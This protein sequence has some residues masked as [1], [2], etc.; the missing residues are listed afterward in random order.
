MNME[1]FSKDIAIIGL[2]CSFPKSEDPSIFFTN[3]LNSVD[4]ISDFTEEDLILAGEDPNLIGEDNY[5]KSKGILKHADCFDADFFGLSPQEASLLDPQ[6]RLF[7]QSCWKSLEHAGYRPDTIRACVG[8]F[9]ST[10]LSS[11]LTENLLPNLDLRKRVGDFQLLLA[12]DKDFLATRVSFKLN[13]TGPSMTIQ[14]GCS[15]SLVATHMACQSI[16]NGDCDIA[17]AGGVSLSFPQIQ[18]YLYQ[19]DMI[20]SPDGRCRPFDAKSKGTVRGSGVGVVV[21]KLL[22]DALQDEDPIIAIIKGSAINNDGYQKVGFTAPSV[23][24]QTA[25]INEALE[26]A[27]IPPQTIRYV[28]GH[29]TGTPL[30][31][32]IELEALSTAFNCDDSKKQY[33]ALGSV[34]SNIGHLD[35]ASGIAGLIK[36]ALSLQNKTIPPT[37]HWEKS[38]RRIQL[39][40][41]PFYVNTQPITWEKNTFPRRAAIS[42]FG[43]GGTNAHVILEEAPYLKSTLQEI[44]SPQL[45]LFSANSKKSLNYLINNLGI[46]LQNNP[47]ISL[48]D[49]AYTLAVA[50]KPLPHRKSFIFSNT[51]EAAEILLGK[52]PDKSFIKNQETS[53]QPYANAWEKGKDPYPHQIFSPHKGKRIH[54]PTYPFEKISHWIAS[55]EKKLSNIPQKTQNHSFSHSSYEDLII[56]LWQE[57]LGIDHIGWN[58][59][60]FEIG[61]SSLTA[62][63]FISKIDKSLQSL[64]SVVKLYEYPTPSMLAMLFKKTIH[65]S[66]PLKQAQKEQQALS[67]ELHL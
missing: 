26:F 12:N 53:L 48:Q 43:I 63:E 39:E 32:P 58:D 51:R 34:K 61:G 42:S 55:P 14:T 54:L 52:L 10:S 65:N 19:K 4:C 16:L 18:G 28:E 64:L 21:L 67:Q 24:Q 62:I 17:L 46:F 49:V 40:E 37:L 57:I 47:S 2:D 3:L 9:G 27:E 13:L 22:C 25:V 29:G 31:D 60:F 36:A 56:S 44:H 35:A 8:V 30:G 11:Y 45:L 41:S 1:S 7:L 20:G 66:D 23:Q 50:R 15:S 6:Q 59:N 38:N 33:C 5:I